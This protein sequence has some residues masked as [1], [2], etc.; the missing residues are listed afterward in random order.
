MSNESLISSLRVWSD[1][2]PPGELKAL[3]ST[4]AK[5]LE[6]AESGHPPAPLVFPYAT[7]VTIVGNGSGI[8]FESYNAFKA[9]AEL[10]QQ[11][12]GRTLKLFPKQY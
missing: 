11:D 12:E 6:K 2:C 9:G 4:A 1:G 8:L 3:L 7:R 5:A 10:H